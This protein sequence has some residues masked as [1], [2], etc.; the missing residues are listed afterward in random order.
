[1]GQVMAKS[2]SYG[3]RDY[4]AIE[5][6]LMGSDYGRWFL[7]E[8]LARNRSEE[9]QRLLEA[10]D[11][12]E[13]SLGAGVNA[14]RLPRLREIALE[15]DAALGDALA[16]IEPETTVPSLEPPVE[17]ILEAVEDINSFLESLTARRVY[18]RLSEKIRA[19]LADIQASC[20]QVDSRSEAAQTLTQVLS[21]LRARLSA[22]D[23]GLEAPDLSNDGDGPRFPRKLLEELAA[24]FGPGRSAPA[25]G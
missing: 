15:I 6:A 10:L 14:D 17:T 25:R 5:D 9:T 1:M 18:Q 19:R 8:Y 12:L 23:V 4:R 13:D 16:R 3:E 7:G 22:V 11:R 2:W 20:A 21:D 24:A